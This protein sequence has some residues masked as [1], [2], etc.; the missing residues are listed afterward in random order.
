[1]S[2]GVGSILLN[3][4][5]STR[6]GMLVN[7]LNLYIINIHVTPTPTQ[8]NH[9]TLAGGSPHQSYKIIF[10]IKITKRK[11]VTKELIVTI[12]Q[13]RY[14]FKKIGKINTYIPQITATLHKLKGLFSFKWNK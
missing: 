3:G 7:M 1:M 9:N 13:N 6:G 10:I 11:I 8:N 12:N 5:G 14:I 4:L 2:V